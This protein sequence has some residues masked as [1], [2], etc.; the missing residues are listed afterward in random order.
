MSPI[1]DEIKAQI[2]CCLSSSNHDHFVSEP[3][4]LLCGH[5]ACLTCVE[6]LKENQVDCY[7]CKKVLKK[8]EM[9]N[10]TPNQAIKIIMSC[11]FKEINEEIDFKIKKSIESL[12]GI[13]KK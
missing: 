5:N 12:N 3:I 10:R 11:Y 1:K 8:D 7:H 9:N 2:E 13:F 4:L 6:G